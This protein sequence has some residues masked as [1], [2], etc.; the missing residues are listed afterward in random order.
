MRFPAPSSSDGRT[1]LVKANG[2]IV[3][4]HNGGANHYVSLSGIA[5]YAAGIGSW[6]AIGTGIA[7]YGISFS[8]ETNTEYGTPAYYKDPYGVVW[9]RG[10]VRTSNTYG[11]S[12]RTV[13]VL[14]DTHRAAKNQ[15]IAGTSAAGVTGFESL[16]TAGDVRSKNGAPTA[17]DT[18]HSLHNLKIF[19]AEA[20]TLNVYKTFPAR[21][22]WVWIGNPYPEPGY[23][24]REDGLRMATGLVNTGANNTPLQDYAEREISSEFGISV[25]PALSNNSYCRVDLTGDLKNRISTEVS[26]SFVLGP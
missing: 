13:V 15:H 23:I 22:P 1:I 10:L 6:S 8:A 5:F 19:T 24:L 9:F 21:A 20:Y 3:Y 26:S 14:P 11:A 25:H 7:P 17:V 4:P 12:D 16:S 2:D 18:S